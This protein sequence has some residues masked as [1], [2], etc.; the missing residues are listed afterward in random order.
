[1]VRLSGA[2][3]APW[4]EGRLRIVRLLLRGFTNAAVAEELSCSL[5]TIF[6][7]LA[8]LADDLGL[9]AESGVDRKTGVMLAYLQMVGALKTGNGAYD[10]EPCRCLHFHEVAVKAR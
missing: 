9:E 5:T 7:Q 6:S 8:Q 2:S 3:T 1:M 10:R 4:T